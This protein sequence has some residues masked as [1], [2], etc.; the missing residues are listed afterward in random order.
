MKI[1]I[2]TNVIIAAFTTRGL[3]NGLLELCLYNHEVYISEYIINECEN[4]FRNKIKLPNVIVEQ[5]ENFLR[6]NLIIVVPTKIDENICRD[7]KDMPIIGTVVS[8]G[9]EII[10][11]GDKDLLN[12]KNYRKIKIL[13][14]RE[15][16]NILKKKHDLFNHLFC[17]I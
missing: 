8:A 12:I 7:K 2:D 10:I 14:P 16:W 3:C 15:F 5:I 4:K 6:N 13:S 11:S 1:V 17:I 9:A